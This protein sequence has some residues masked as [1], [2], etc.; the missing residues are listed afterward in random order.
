MSVRSVV[1]NLRHSAPPFILPSH[2]NVHP[3]MSQID[4]DGLPSVKSVQIC[5]P[6]LS[7]S[8]KS[9][10]ICGP[11]TPSA[12]MLPSHLNFDPQMSQIDSDGLPSVKSADPASPNRR[13][14]RTQVSGTA[15]S[16]SSTRRPL[17]RGLHLPEFS[18]PLQPFK[19]SMALAS[20]SSIATSTARLA[21]ASRAWASWRNWVIMASLCLRRRFGK[22]FGGAVG[23]VQRLRRLPAFQAQ[24]SQQGFVYSC[25][26]MP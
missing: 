25:G 22:G 26:S 14:L 2:W 5:G 8:V 11:E 15:V 4:A 24:R 6:C 10:Q 1:Q 23:V 13:N 17:D 19:V 12:C 3:Q 21:F 20:P 18:R 9:A 7:E 16:S